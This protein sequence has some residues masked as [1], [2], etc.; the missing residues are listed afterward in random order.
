[1]S[2]FS[3]IVGRLDEELEA[4]LFARDTMQKDYD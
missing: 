4:H 1:M 2:M 3:L